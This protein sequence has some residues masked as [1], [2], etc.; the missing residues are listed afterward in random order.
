MGDFYGNIID[1]NLLA[2]LNGYLFTSTDR[3]TS[4]VCLMKI[5]SFI[6]TMKNMIFRCSRE[7]KNKETCNYVGCTFLCCR[8]ICIS[9]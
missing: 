1:W 6:A 7:N 4:R 8:L 3:V 9:L 5:T 2:E